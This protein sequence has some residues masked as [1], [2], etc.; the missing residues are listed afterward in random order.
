MHEYAEMSRLEIEEQVNLRNH[1]N[2][3]LAI[4]FALLSAAALAVL[5]F[6]C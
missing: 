4:S 5:Y 2:G 1:M 3:V 6:A